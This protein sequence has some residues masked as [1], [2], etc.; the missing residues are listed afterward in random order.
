MNLPIF[1]NFWLLRLL[2]YGRLKSRF[3]EIVFQWG[4]KNIFSYK[5]FS[6]DPFLMKNAHYFL[7]VKMTLLPT[8]SSSRADQKSCGFKNAAL[9]LNDVQT[10]KINTK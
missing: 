5:N 6:S 8:K 9:A 4:R 2:R 1:R 10:C 3:Y 7:S